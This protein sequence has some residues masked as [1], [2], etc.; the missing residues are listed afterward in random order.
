MTDEIK[1]LQMLARKS[2]KETDSVFKKS[3]SDTNNNKYESVLSDLE[4]IALNNLK[5]SE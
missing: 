4:S 5:K 2:G 1:S 3:N